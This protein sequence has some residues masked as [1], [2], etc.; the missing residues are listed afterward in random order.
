MAATLPDFT[1]CLKF[2][3]DATCQRTAMSLAGIPPPSTSGSGASR[4][5]SDTPPGLGS[6]EATPSR[7]G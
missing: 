3:S 5:H 1:V 7:N 2:G 6:P 4:V